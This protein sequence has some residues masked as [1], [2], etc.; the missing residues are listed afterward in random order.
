MGHINYVYNFRYRNLWVDVQFVKSKESSYPIL[1][2]IIWPKGYFSV[3]PDFNSS[4][5]LSAAST[6]APRTAYSI[7]ISLEEIVSSVNAFFLAA[8]DPPN[9]IDD[10]LSRMLPW[11]KFVTMDNHSINVRPFCIIIESVW[12]TTAW[13]SMI[14]LLDWEN[15]KFI[16]QLVSIQHLVGSENLS[17]IRTLPMCDVVVAYK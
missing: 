4:L 8:V 7:F 15:L 1:V 16:F 6:T 13:I 10:I 11:V 14:N 12:L 5:I 17:E 2:Y 9:F 3:F